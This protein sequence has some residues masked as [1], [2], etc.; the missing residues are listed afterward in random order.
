[1]YLYCTY[2][3]IH[4]FFLFR[5]LSSL[6]TILFENVSKLPTDNAKSVKLRELLDDI[7][8]ILKRPTIPQLEQ[9]SQPTMTTLAERTAQQQP[10]SGGGIRSTISNVFGN[11]GNYYYTVLP[12]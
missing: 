10:K 7:S 4:I 5:Y 12:L 2:Q 11:M 1:M 6:H 3:K 9:I 8:N